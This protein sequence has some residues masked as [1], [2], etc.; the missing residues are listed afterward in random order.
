MGGA[1]ADVDIGVGGSAHDLRRP[2][3]LDRWRRRIRR[4][5]FGVTYYGGPCATYSPLHDPQLRTVLVGACPAAASRPIS[6]GGGGDATAAPPRVGLVSGGCP[7][8]AS[9]PR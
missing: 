2:A 4:R 5:E 1:V 9:R 8:A 7:A 3:V 6:V